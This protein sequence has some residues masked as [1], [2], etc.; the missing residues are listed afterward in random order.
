MEYTGL[1]CFFDSEKRVV[2]F[3]RPSA[4]QPLFTRGRSRFSRAAIAQIE[5]GGTRADLG[6]AH[7]AGIRTLVLRDSFGRRI[8]RDR[9]LVELEGLSRERSARGPGAERAFPRGLNGR[10]L[11]FPGV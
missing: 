7:G 5:S 8:F 4:S 9:V 1:R 10:L 11:R 6:E 2:A 3:C